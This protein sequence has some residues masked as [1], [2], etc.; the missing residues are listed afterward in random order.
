MKFVLN[1]SGIYDRLWSLALNK[2]FDKEAA[3]KNFDLFFENFKKYWDE[4]S[5]KKAA[6]LIA[7]YSGLEWKY[8]NLMVYFVNNLD[9]DGF[10]IPLTIKINDDYLDVCSTLIH[11]TI[12]NILFQNDEKVKSVIE[13]LNKM[14]PNEDKKTILHIIVNALDKKVFIEIYGEDNFKVVFLKIKDYKGLK[15]AYEILEEVYPKLG[16]NILE[17][18]MNL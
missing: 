17:S 15:R 4:E 1:Y 6:Q 18:L 12:H 11:E 5:E 10:S 2:Q 13:H 9:I 14:F 3:K 7:K 8:D 16:E